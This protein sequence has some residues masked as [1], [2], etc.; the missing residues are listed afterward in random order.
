MRSDRS[1]AGQSSR[2]VAKIRSTVGEAQ[3]AQGRYD[4]AATLFDDVALA[5]DFVE[6][7]TLP[8][9]ARLD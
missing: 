2:C 6:F 5:D 1:S 8:G 7:L 3:Y 4:E 9:Y